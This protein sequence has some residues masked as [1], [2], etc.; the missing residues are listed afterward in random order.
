MRRISNRENV[1]IAA[2]GNSLRSIIMKLEDSMPEGV[3]GV[4]QETAVPWMYEIDSAG[5]ATSK[6]ILK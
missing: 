6:K 1:L 2:H 3:P 4:E 5:Q